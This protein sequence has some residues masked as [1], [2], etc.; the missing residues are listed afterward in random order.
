MGG[1][2]I[3][4]SQVQLGTIT[5]SDKSLQ[6]LHYNALYL[7]A[8]Y[9]PDVLLNVSEAAIEDKTKANAI[10]KTI[11]CLQAVWFTSLVI[12]RL[13]TSNAICLLELNVG[14]HAICC[15]LTY[16]AWWYKPLD[17]EQPIVLD[18]GPYCGWLLSMDFKLNCSRI[19]GKHDNLSEGKLQL[20]YHS[21]YCHGQEIRKSLPSSL[22]Y[23][24]TA[25]RCSPDHSSGSA[26]NDA[27]V[28]TR[29]DSGQSLHGFYLIPTFQA[30]SQN[31]YTYLDDVDI[32]WMKSFSDSKFA[33][34]PVFSACEKALITKKSK[35]LKLFEKSRTSPRFESLSLRVQRTV[36]RKDRLDEEKGAKEVRGPRNSDWYLEG[37]L[38]AAGV[39]YGG[40]HLLAWYAPFQ[41]SY[42]LW[43]WRVSCIIVIA[44][45]PLLIFYPHNFVFSLPSPLD[46]LRAIHIGILILIYPAARMFLVIECFINLAHLPPEVYQQPAWSRYIPHLTAG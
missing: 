40:L 24:T 43:L 34:N 30:D 17:V 4:A 20:V 39:L 26:V 9:A 28:G 7:L 44:G 13:A 18:A 10:A 11:A 3:D 22:G 32:R 25:T 5:V 19:H 33:E 1:F 16:A 35:R 37:G 31:L 6:V 14:L 41:R 23:N 46:R 38:I 45:P 27:S 42:E 15:L 36:P 21:A 8:E 29:L 2:A 12:G